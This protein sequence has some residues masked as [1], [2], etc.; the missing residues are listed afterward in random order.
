MTWAIAPLESRGIETVRALA[1]TV[2]RAHYPPIIGAA[3]TEYML[4]Q[5]YAA[6]VIAA[7][8]ERSDLWWDTLCE[9]GAMIAFASSFL[10][11]ARSAVKLDKLYVHPAHQRRGC[12]GALIQ[13]V[14]R[15]AA[16]LGASKLVLAVNKRNSTAIAAYLR[17][18][19]TIAE[20]VVKDIGGGF[21]MDD[22]IMERAV[23]A[24]SEEACRA[25]AS[26]PFA[27][28]R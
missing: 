2:W 28:Q 24:T 10:E 8:L 23:H 4:E 5:R 13:H 22:Y 1:H 11:P 20:A 3:Q 25:Q 17:H 16:R 7:E 18:G 21:V 15:R 12:G 19:F 26:A 14:A 27:G 9:D 6:H